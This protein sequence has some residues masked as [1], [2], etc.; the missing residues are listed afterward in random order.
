MRRLI[1]QTLLIARR[2]TTLL[3]G[4][5][6]FW[7]L[8]GVFFLATSFVYLAQVIGFANSAFREEQNL[9]DTITIAVV[10]PLFWTVHFFL[11]IQ[12]P[13]LTM[14]TIAE[15]RRTG[16][17]ALLMTTPANEWAIVL[18]KW[19]ANSAVLGLYLALTLVFALLTDWISDPDWPVILGCVAALV[20]AAGA[21]TALGIAF[22][23]GT[24]SQVVSAVLTYTTLF[25]MLI[26]S[27]LSEAMGAPEMQALVRHLA[28]TD[29]MRGFFTG[30]VA[31]HDAVYFAGVTFLG[32]FVA[33]R[34]L[35]SLR[36]R[37]V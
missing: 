15:E 31:L 20:M 34:Q 2:E 9:T 22:S 27:A 25:S 28:F 5:P 18:G 1:R 12:I 19:I 13:L 36:W 26:L 33:V 10:E 35:E 11:M 24:D 6:L 4:T 32:L 14:R 30:N 37:A 29:H 23:A 17:L 3:L 8:A 16:T 7:V 21:Y